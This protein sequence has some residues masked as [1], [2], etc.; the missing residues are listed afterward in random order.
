MVVYVG[1]GIR[2][3]LSIVSSYSEFSQTHSDMKIV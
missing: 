2:S 1:G 3:G